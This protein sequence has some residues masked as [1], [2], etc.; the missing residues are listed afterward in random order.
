[1]EKITKKKKWKNGGTNQ[2][3]VNKMALWVQSGSCQIKQINCIHAA[4]SSVHQARIDRKCWQQKR[5][6]YIVARARAKVLRIQ[7]RSFSLHVSNPSS[8]RF[9]SLSLLLNLVQQMTNLMNVS[10]SDP[11]Q[12]KICQKLEPFVRI[13]LKY[14]T[15]SISV[16]N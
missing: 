11:L 13:P 8:F 14:F 5:E 16:S 3:L 7:I 6:R 4:P 1:M 2:Q 9:F 15:L 12:V 10:S